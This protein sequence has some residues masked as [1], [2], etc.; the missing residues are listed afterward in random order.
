MEFL[1]GLDPQL[2][3]FWYIA[4]P[5]SLVFVLQT[6]LTFVGSG[7]SDGIEA[8]FDGDLDGAEAP[9]Q[10]F[11]LRNLINFLLGFSWAGIS[12]YT[13]IPNYPL[14]LLIS[15]VIG[16]AF[17]YSFF[18]II[19]QIQKLGE[20][21]TFRLEKTLNKIADVYLAIPGN[22]QGK[23]KIMV[24][25]NGS[26]RELDAMTEKNKIETNATVRILRVESGNILIVEKL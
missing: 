20:D 10:L 18:L 19:K 14:I 25:L 2:K 26:V 13:I 12:F 5:V 9:F 22:M 4:I 1:D 15:L 17:V 7:G 21:N 3:L 23:G 11:S 24:S 16:F 8:D 6:I